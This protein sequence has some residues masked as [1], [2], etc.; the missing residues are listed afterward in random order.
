MLKKY[1][2]IPFAVIVF[3]TS[4]QH[5]PNVTFWH[6]TIV[7]NFGTNSPFCDFVS[8]EWL[9]Q[10]S[11]SF[12]VHPA[13]RR[14]R[15]DVSLFCCC[16]VTVLHRE[17]KEFYQ[18]HDCRVKRWSWRIRKSFLFTFE[19]T[20]DF[21][22]MVQEYVSPVRVHK[23]TFEMVMAVSNLTV[24]LVNS[25]LFRPCLFKTCL[26]TFIPRNSTMYFSCSLLRLI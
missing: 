10:F 15:F 25:M 12:Q 1:L 14:I 20:S 22:K 17:W 7:A 3:C 11:T 18:Q 13:S 16:T 4:W 2:P 6:A 5:Y 26:F 23:F 8:L 9:F 19:N 24:K 21:E